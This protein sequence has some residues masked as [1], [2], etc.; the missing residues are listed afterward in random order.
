MGLRVEHGRQHQMHG[1]GPLSG[2]GQQ[3][4]AADPAQVRLRHALEQR[5]D[6]LVFRVP[7]GPQAGE[8]V[9]EDL[10]QAGDRRQV[11]EDAA[12]P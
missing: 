12:E 10:V 7:G 8:V 11:A 2:L 1:H 3:G 5:D 6:A 4:E 9:V